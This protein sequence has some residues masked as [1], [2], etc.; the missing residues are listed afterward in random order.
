MTSGYQIK[1]VV[2]PGFIARAKQLGCSL[3]EIRAL[4]EA[5]DGERCGP[6]QDRL[7]PTVA[8]KL[9]DAAA[10]IAELQALT[11]DL[12]RAAA[13]LEQHRPDGPCDDRC[14]CVG[15]PGDPGDP[16]HPGAA[17]P[18]TLGRKPSTRQERRRVPIT[19]A[20]AADARP[21]VHARFGDPT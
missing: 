5:G 9:A 13:T 1:E 21:I 16:G 17:I 4:T 15:D 3:E 12:R 18:V 7:Q 19:C 20:P 11:K 8:Q 2:R 6:V 14:G 10:R